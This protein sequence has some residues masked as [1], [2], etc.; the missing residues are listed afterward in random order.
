MEVTGSVTGAFVT[1]TAP[2]VVTKAPVTEPVTSMAPTDC[3]DLYGITEEDIINQ[4]GSEEPI[5]EDAIKIIHGENANVTIE[6]SQLWTEDV[7]LTFFIQYHS[8]THE[9]VCEAIPD[10]SYEDTIT[11][12]LECYDGWT[13]VGIFIYFDDVTLE[14][15][16]EC[17]PPDSDDDS[18]VAYYFEIPCKPI[19]MSFEPSSAPSMPVPPTLAP[20][21]SPSAIS[22]ASIQP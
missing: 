11:K 17:R 19:C 10:F 6:I 3:Y 16:E 14:E 4:I 22:S 7:N 21:S 2:D 15:C 5:P 8:D 1:T 20:S 12:D 9:S 18:V 13:D